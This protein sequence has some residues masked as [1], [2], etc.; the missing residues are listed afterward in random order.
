MFFNFKQYV[1]FFAALFIIQTFYGLIAVSNANNNVIEYQHVQDEYDYHMVLR[2]LNED[3][4]L[5]LENNSAAVFKNDTIFKILR[6][7]QNRN[8][9]AAQNRYDMYLYFVRDKD[10]SCERFY[11]KYLEPLKSLGREGES[12]VI[13]ETPLLRFEHNEQSNLSSFIFTT[14]LLLAVSIFLLTALYN[15]RVNQYKFTY[16]VYMTFGADFKSCS[17]PPFGSCSLSLW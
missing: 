3:Q 14:L 5:Y 10:I 13:T 11:N 6:Y 7:E 1:S 9:M 12:F 8:Y 15:I 17:A 4:Y 2:D 16:G